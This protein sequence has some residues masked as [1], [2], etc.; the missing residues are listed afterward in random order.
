MDSVRIVEAIVV[1]IDCILRHLPV[2]IACAVVGGE[3]L[4]M[5][6]WCSR[7]LNKSGGALVLKLDLRPRHTVPKKCPDKSFV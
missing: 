3:L 7:K 6:G 4:S 1:I 5:V 2:F